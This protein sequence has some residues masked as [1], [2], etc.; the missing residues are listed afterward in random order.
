MMIFQKGK[1]KPADDILSHSRQEREIYAR[2][3]DI[4]GEIIATGE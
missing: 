3:G 4:A 2:M 1:I